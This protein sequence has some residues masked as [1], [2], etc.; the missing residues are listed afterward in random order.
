MPVSGLGE[1]G[2]GGEREGHKSRFICTTRGSL[3]SI[4]SSS[5]ASGFGGTSSANVVVEAVFVR[6][7]TSPIPAE[8]TP[9]ELEEDRGGGG[10]RPRFM[11]EPASSGFP[12]G[13]GSLVGGRGRWCPPL[14][15]R[16]RT[17]LAISVD[18]SGD[19]GEEEKKE[20]AAEE[21]RPAPSSWNPFASFSYG[22][23]YAT[24]RSFFASAVDTLTEE[25]K[26]ESSPAILVS[27]HGEREEKGFG[28]DRASSDGS[29]RATAVQ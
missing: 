15:P 14:P 2:R 3:F 27:F 13:S 6:E 18:T 26:L 25:D 9:G 20:E 19:A 10:P 7:D 17:V 16:P 4:P 24:L 11:G 12:G 23:V 8:G 5:L 22:L 28:V 29:A 1:S 21:M